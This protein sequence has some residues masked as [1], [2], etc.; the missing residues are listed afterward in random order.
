MSV[1]WIR[2][3]DDGDTEAFL[4]VSNRD[5]GGAYLVMR[6][7]HGGSTKDISVEL[8]H[9]S[10]EAL[11]AVCT[12]LSKRGTGRRAHVNARKEGSGT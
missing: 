3:K 9:A 11:G 12:A 6:P 4:E 10:L 8:D 1:E 2:F 5:G 7:S